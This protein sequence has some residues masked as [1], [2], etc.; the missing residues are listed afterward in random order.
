MYNTPF[1]LFFSPSCSAHIK[2][3]HRVHDAL[4]FSLS[5]PSRDSGAGREMDVNGVMIGKMIE[6]R[7]KFPSSEPCRL[8]SGKDIG[9]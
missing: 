7:L 3:G 2:A 1:L 5:A 6:K 9:C 8:C 4:L